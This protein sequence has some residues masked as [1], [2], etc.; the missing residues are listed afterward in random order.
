MLVLSKESS[1]PIG[2]VG[3]GGRGPNV[4]SYLPSFNVEYRVL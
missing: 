1:E 3:D 2:L 4:E